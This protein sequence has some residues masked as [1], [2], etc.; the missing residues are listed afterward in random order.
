MAAA[1]V[2]QRRTIMSVPAVGTEKEMTDQAIEQIRARVKYQ[3]ELI[4]AHEHDSHD[5][6][7]EMWRWLNLSFF[8]GLP[9]VLASGLYS[10]VF[11]KHS[12]RIEGPLP[13]FMAVRSKEFPWQCG[14]C[15][16]FDL[17]C[18]KECKAAKKK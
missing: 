3:K 11:D 4:Q 6:T 10:V 17:N 1:A 2:L 15:D 12:H 16:L 8:V 9:I 5:D 14:E 13:D 18:W 7:G